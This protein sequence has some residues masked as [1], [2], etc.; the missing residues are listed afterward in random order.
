MVFKSVINV[1][2]RGRARV[3]LRSSM[4]NTIGRSHHSFGGTPQQGLRAPP[5]LVRT[6][7]GISDMKRTKLRISNDVS[8]WA[9][10][11]RH[12]GSQLESPCVAEEVVFEVQPPIFSARCRL[13]KFS[14]SFT[15]PP[16]R[17]LSHER[18]RLKRS[19]TNSPRRET[20]R[21]ENSSYYDQPVKGFGILELLGTMF[22]V[23]VLA[24][25]YAVIYSVF[26]ECVIMLAFFL[27]EIS[28]K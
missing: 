13:S 20:P 25:I 26:R 18:R 27:D 24:V 22:W 16:C 1:C 15:K 4:R 2:S 19:E 9:A 14:Q 5:F 12:R 3:P 28:G 8:V 21:P 7:L 23:L 11:A 17:R 6:G 10:V